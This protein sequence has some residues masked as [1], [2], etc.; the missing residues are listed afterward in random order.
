MTCGIL[1][2]RNSPVE[3][4][5]E[6]GCILEDAHN[7]AHVFKDDQGR[8]IEWE[9]DYS[10]TCGCWD[11]AEGGVCMVYRVIKKSKK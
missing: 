1:F 10:C 11:D 5:D 3:P 2:Q 4:K 7:S 8:L 6:H 9:D